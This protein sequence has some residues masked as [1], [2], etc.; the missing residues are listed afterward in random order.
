MSE[1]QQGHF[2]MFFI[3]RRVRPPL[4]LSII[5]VFPTNLPSKHPLQ[6]LC[7]QGVVTG[8]FIT[9]RHIWQLNPVSTTDT[10]QR[11]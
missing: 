8:K 11:F 3:A 9:C 10:Q 1:G 5:R 6:K 4:L 2:I 7:A